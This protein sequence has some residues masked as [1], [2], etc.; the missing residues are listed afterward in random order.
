MVKLCVSDVFFRSCKIVK[1][2]H[3]HSKHENYL[4]FY[5]SCLFKS[6]VK[7]RKNTLQVSKFPLF[8][9]LLPSSYWPDPIALILLPLSYWLRYI[10]LVIIPILLPSYYC[11]HHIALVLLPS[12]YCH[13]PIATVLL[14]PSYCPSY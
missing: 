5:S 7:T 3:V 1:Q 4:N 12:S 11:H 8:P 14:T 2:A 10:V 13:C 9:V 6:M